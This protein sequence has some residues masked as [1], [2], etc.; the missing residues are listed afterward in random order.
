MKGSS[1]EYRVVFSRRRTLSLSVNGA[2]EIVVRAPAGTRRAEIERFIEAHTDWIERRRAV[3]EASH[4]DLTDGAKIG[5]GGEVYPIAEGRSAHLADGRLYLPAERREQAL[6]ALLRRIAR[7]RMTAYA[8]EYAARF[9]FVFRA[10]RISSA[11]GRWGSCSAR[12]DLA[13]SF[14]TALLDEEKARYL[15]VHELC[16]TRH[17]DHSP[18]FWTE[19]GAILPNYRQTRRA[20]QKEGAIMLF[21]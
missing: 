4:I 19:V 11:R 1:E 17:M 21:L 8:R 18:A 9:G 12:G 6:I 10:I 16:H 3:I 7:E 14:R 5:I 2:G 15:V 20:L 13:F